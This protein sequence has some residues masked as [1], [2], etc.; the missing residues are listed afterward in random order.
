MAGPTL[1][2][3]PEPK[4][5]LT[6]ITSSFQ[7]FAPE[8]S[9]S[10]PRSTIAQH[11]NTAFLA[12][13]AV[14]GLAIMATSADALHVFH[15]THLGADFQLPV[16]PRMLDIKP[17]ITGV[18]CGVI[19]FI[20]NCVALVGQFVPALKRNPLSLPTLIPLAIA[21]IAA[22]VGAA[23]PFNTLTSSTSW[24]VQSW[25]CQWSNI[26]TSA[27]P[28]WGTLCSESRAAGIMSVCVI[29]FDAL[30]IGSILASMMMKGKSNAVQHEE[31]WERKGSAGDMS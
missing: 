19:V 27:A 6:V 10:P 30:V 14:L 7:E 1:S 11:A 4:Q 2:P 17:T 23:I 25:S 3:S 15:S 18:V 22:V 24:S 9:R 29:P 21:L 12:I 31:Q 5:S 26:S 20:M 8:S 16:W 28:H 13:G